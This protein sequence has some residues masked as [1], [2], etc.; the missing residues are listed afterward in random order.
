ME[1]LHLRNGL[2]DVS[3]LYL[4]YW[5]IASNRPRADII[6]L[7][8]VGVLL[9]GVFIYWQWFLEKA[10]DER[11]RRRDEKTGEVAGQPLS[12]RWGERLPPP[13]MKLSLW[14]RA[15]GRFAV[16]MAIAFVAWASFISWSFWMQVSGCLMLYLWFFPA[17]IP[18]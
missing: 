1:N 15:K 18:L 7:L 5:S 9:V 8:I 16:T 17:K 3:T 2:P 10:Q 11:Q 13:T 12:R 14:G 6:A 4:L